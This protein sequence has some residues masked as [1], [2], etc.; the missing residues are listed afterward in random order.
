E[1]SKKKLTSAKFYG[2]NIKERMNSKKSFL[3]K[4]GAVIGI[5]YTKEEDEIE[6]TGSLVDIDANTNEAITRGYDDVVFGMKRH[7]ATENQTLDIGAL[8]SSFLYA[9]EDN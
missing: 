4:L 9:V 6:G 7:I 2:Q 5:G 1:D 8:M 3:G